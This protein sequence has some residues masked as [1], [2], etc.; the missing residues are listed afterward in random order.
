[1]STSAL[2]IDFGDRTPEIH[3]QAWVAPGATIV[4]S[5]RLSAGAS[6]WYG[7]VLRADTDDISLGADSN[8]Q[9]GC[10]VHADPGFATVVGSGVSVGHRAVLHGCTVED[11]AL[12]GMGAIV[13]N[14]ARIGAGSLVAAGAVVLEGTVVPPGS[15]VAGLPARVRRDLT[16]EERAGIVRN[17][18][19][20][21][22][23]ARAHAAAT[24]PR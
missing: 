14:G 2:V 10:V 20:Y 6:V 21:V 8:L 18:Q 13:L 11:G 19:R 5:V 17:T 3:P 4:G 16:E 12:I 9:D 24:T 22:E 23:R 7:C 15:L 1:V